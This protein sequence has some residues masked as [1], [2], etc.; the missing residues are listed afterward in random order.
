[1]IEKTVQALIRIVFREGAFDAKASSRKIFWNTIAYPFWR[2]SQTMSTAM[3]AG[4]TPGMRDAWPR[5]TGR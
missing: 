2:F 3:S 1:M 4:D 5:E